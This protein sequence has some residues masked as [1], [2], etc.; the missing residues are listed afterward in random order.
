MVQNAELRI[1]QKQNLERSRKRNDGI[2]RPEEDERLNPPV[3]VSMLPEEPNG[4]FNCVHC[5]NSPAAGEHGLCD[6]C[7]DND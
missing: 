5:G 6:D 2:W 7:L 1:L 4:N 3:M